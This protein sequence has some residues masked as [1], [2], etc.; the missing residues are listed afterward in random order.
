MARAGRRQPLGT[1]YQ[2]AWR[3]VPSNPLSGSA[4]MTMSATGALSVISG[5]V[6][7]SVGTSEHRFRYVEVPALQD[8]EAVQRHLQRALDEVS[9]ALNP[10]R[11]VADGGTG[12]A[13]LSAGAITIGTGAAAMETVPVGAETYQLTVVAGKPAWAP[14][15]GVGAGE[16]N[17]ATNVG[18]GGVSIVNGKVGVDLQ[19]RSVR[20]GSSKI[21][22]ALD[23]GNKRVDF[24][25]VTGAIAG[26]VCA[27][28]DARLSDARAPTGAAGGVL[29]G[30]YPSPAFALDMATQAELDAAVAT[31]LAA[32]K[33]DTRYELLSNDRPGT[34]DYVE[35]RA[36]QVASVDTR[37]GIR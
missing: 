8:F 20:A 27:G 19:F 3:T 35:E 31:L 37:A 15:G 22:V 34:Y 24:D 23:A 30:T 32:A 16:A 17:T 10:I 21:T 26:T 7:E 4:S 14:P 9:R 33:V 28:D 29:S 1:Q 2:A 11:T 18:V 13:E 12:L 5:T 6:F 25:V 36:G